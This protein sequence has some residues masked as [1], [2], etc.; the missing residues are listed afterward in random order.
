MYRS[1]TPRTT[2][3]PHSAAAAID[4]R[5]LIKGAAASIAAAGLAVATGAVLPAIQPRQAF[6]ADEVTLKL[7]TVGSV[8]FWDAAKETLAEQGIKLEI[9]E[10][11]DL[12]TPNNALHNKELD[13]N[14]F[15]HR[16]YLRNECETLGYE[17]ENIGNTIVVPLNLFSFKV[18]STS[19]LKEGDKV[20]IPN[21]T[22]NGGRALRVLQ[23]AGLITLKDNDTL[24][25]TVDDIQDNPQG[26][27]ITELAANTVA[28]ALPDLAAG[29]VN[30]VYA[31]DFG[32]END[33]IIYEDTDL[34]NKEYWNLIAVRAEDVENPERYALMKKVVDAFHSDGTL[35][36]L[37]DVF[38]D[39]Y[40]PVGWDEDPQ[41]EK[42]GEAA[43][44]SSA[45]KTAS[46]AA[47]SAAAAS[48]STDKS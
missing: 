8:E 33:D 19:E 31:L 26:I 4:R 28:S 38:H 37:H 12:V 45:D 30:G 18:K 6:A 16:I 29:I 9:V 46:A 48:A 23:S 41:Q 2:H 11:G 13:L 17:I 21:D 14:A 36:I 22:V 35:Q 39:Y 27:V 47:A 43:A 32:L 1:S 10:F 42:D 40:I 34:D 44:S 15:Q 20:G 3:A 24:T 7:G 25:P 5:S